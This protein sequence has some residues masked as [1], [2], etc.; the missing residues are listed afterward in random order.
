[1]DNKVH[2]EVQYDSEEGLVHSD[3][4]PPDCDFTQINATYREFL[5]KNLDEWL[6]NSKGT[7][8]FYIKS[9][10]HIIGY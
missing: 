1:M 2:A 9:S 5:H 3:I 10:N 8:I 7:G 4:C 6:N